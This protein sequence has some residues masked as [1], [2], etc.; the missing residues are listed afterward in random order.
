MSRS[1]RSGWLRTVAALMLAAALPACATIPTSGPVRQGG[2]P[3]VERQDV[4]VPPIGEPPARGASPEDIV[5]GFLRASADF[6]GD[7][8]VARQ[9]LTPEARPRWRPSTGTSVYDRARAPLTVQAGADGTVTARGAQVATIDAEGS[10]RRTSQGSEVARTFRL[11]RI[12]GEW[13]IADLEDGLLLSLVDVQ[14]SFRPVSLY[15]LSPSRNTLVPDTV[16]LPELPGLSTRLVSRLLRG[17]SA[18][19]RGAVGTAFPRGT[20]LEVQS[21]P[22]RDGLATVRLDEAPLRAEDDAREQMSAQVVWT[23]KQLGPE[24]QRI[25]ITAGGEDLVVSGVSEEQDRDSWQTFD[26]D[27][28]AEGATVYVVR[29]GQVGRIIEGS[30][31][32]VE[33]AAGSGQVSL[34][35]PAVSLDTDRIAIVG[36]GGSMLS[37]GRLAADAPLEPVLTGGDLSQPSWDPIGNLWVV[38]RAAG[39]L[40]VLVDGEGTPTRVELPRLPG[41]SPSQVAVSRDGARVALVTGTRGDARLVVGALT[42]VD[43]LGTEGESPPA[44][45]LVAP[46]EVL[47]DLRGVRDVSWSDAGTLTVLGSRDG[48]PVRPVETSTDGYEVREVEPQNEPVSVAT[49]PVALQT[50]P[51]VVGTSDGRLEQYTAGRGWVSLGPGSDPTYPG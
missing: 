5:L 49:A 24:I 32:P 26:P 47:P 48:L 27:G 42:G 35:T 13:R 41:G 4:A 25:R 28:L 12:G 23:L 39:T 11:D 20:E 6:L 46:G 45:T 7:H 10:Y 14:E 40:L 3:G 29:R 18:S 9:Y 33:G 22:V 37:V 34:R 8:A 36:E 43:A 50:G 30:F 1:P 44:V 21:V 51:L 31:Q 16:L 38:D 19:L 15:F 2:D 17:P